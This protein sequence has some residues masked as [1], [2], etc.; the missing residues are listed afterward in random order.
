MDTDPLKD[1]EDTLVRW[2][3]GDDHEA[4]A[5]AIRSALGAL[6]AARQRR[7]QDLRVLFADH[8]PAEVIAALLVLSDAFVGH[9]AAAQELD[10]DQLI[11]ELTAMAAT[12]SP[13]S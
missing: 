5:A 3:E 1:L 10:R 13:G 2:R 4:A 7:E 9:W 12:W 8:E 6:T 11:T